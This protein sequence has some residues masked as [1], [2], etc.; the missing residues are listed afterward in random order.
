MAL[1]ETETWEA[2]SP[3]CWYKISGWGGRGVDY[4]LEEM[5]FDSFVKGFRVKGNWYMFQVELEVR[6]I[7]DFMQV[8]NSH[9]VV[10]PVLK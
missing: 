7:W 4:F 1:S 5:I 3:F 10:L 9:G 2:P 6:V 8:L